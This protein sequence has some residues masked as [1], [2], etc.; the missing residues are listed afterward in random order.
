M[1][2]LTSGER[3]RILLQLQSQ[4]EQT[5]PGIFDLF[6][7]FDINSGKDKLLDFLEKYCHIEDIIATEAD[8]VAS[9]SEWAKKRIPFQRE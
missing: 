5:M 8:F 9:Y 7:G 2:I 6:G 3:S 1:L 4:L